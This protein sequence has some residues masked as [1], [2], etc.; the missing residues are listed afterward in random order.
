MLLLL[1]AVAGSGCA[2]RMAQLVGTGDSRELR[3]RPEGAP[4]SS[5][6]RPGILLLALDGVDRS[7]LYDVLRRGE[8]PGLARLLGGERGFPHA[9]FDDRYLSTLP[10]STM[11]GW[12]TALTGVPPARHGIVGNEFF[13]RERRQLAAPVPV[14]IDD[15]T[16][17]LACYTDDYVDRLSLAPSVYERM[18][19]DDPAV[20]VWVAMQQFHAGADRLLLTDRAVVAKAFQAFMEDEADR[21]LEGK[22]SRAVYEKLDDEIV[23]VVTERLAHGP[24]PDVLTVYL[25]GTDSYAHIAD[26]GPDA[27]RV[28]YLREVLDPLFTRLADRLEER[29]ALANRFVVVTSDHGHTE[30]LHDDRHSLATTGPDEPPALLEKA[31][32]RVRPFELDVSDTADFDVVLAYQGAMAFVYVADRST[33]SAPGTPCDWTRP[34]RFREDVLALADTIYRNDRT[35]AAVPA[36]EG[37][38][39]MVLA[40]RPVP[41][42]ADDLPFEVYVGNG[43]LEPVATYLRRHPHP[44]YVDL[45][46]RLRDLAVGPHGERAG[47]V[48]LIAHNGDRKRAEDRYYFASRYRSWHGSPSATDSRIPLIVAHPRRS[49]AEIRTLVAGALGARPYQQKLTDVL[50]ALRRTSGSPPLASTATIHAQP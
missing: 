49:T 35:G 39:D 36:L 23:D 3:E 12:V 14:T 8:T 47:D 46:A 24:V 6:D 29:G 25:S 13:I 7:L 10:S 42:A 20:L 22:K 18:R 28:T 11:V 5:P 33:C 44:A 2:L 1:L 50:L 41:Y 30:V 21:H 37:T 17:V 26:E 34:P 4:R 43:R 16:P 9:Y 15:T 48:L 38:I 31:G 45:D 40:R 19:E 32:F 27:A